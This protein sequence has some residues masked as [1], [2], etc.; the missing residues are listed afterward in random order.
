MTYVCRL[1]LNTVSGVSK[2]PITHFHSSVTKC[3]TCYEQQSK[4]VDSRPIRAWNK[5]VNAT[6]SRELCK[7]NSLN[8]DCVVTCKL[9]IL[10]FGAIFLRLIQVGGVSMILMPAWSGLMHPAI[11]GQWLPYCQLMTASGWRQFRSAA[12]STCMVHGMSTILREVLRILRYADLE[13]T[14]SISVATGRHCQI[15]CETAEDTFLSSTVWITALD[16][17]LLTRHCWWAWI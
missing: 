7:L 12:V 6:R 8:V 10:H 3:E 5:Y 13:R 2:R 15:L 4:C 16:I 11:P 14:S 1:S 9:C 17:Y